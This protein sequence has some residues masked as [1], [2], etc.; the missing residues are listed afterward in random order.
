MVASCPTCDYECN[1]E[2][3]VKVHHTKVHGESLVLKEK[4]CEYCGEIDEVYPSQTED[5]FDNYFCSIRCRSDHFSEN[6]SGEDHP[7]WKGGQ[8]EVTCLRCD[9]IQQK[10]P[11]YARD[12]YGWDGEGAVE[13]SKCANCMADPEYNTRIP[14]GVNWQTQRRK[15][16]DRDGNAC[17]VCDMNNEVHKQEYSGFSL[18]VHHI[19]PRRDFYDGETGEFDYE[20]ANDLE[21]LIT[22]CIPHHDEA[23]R[24]GQT[25]F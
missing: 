24:T 8:I 12:K 25:Q 20:A 21:N 15:A 17:V 4:A 7:Q 10:D 14:T 19:I 18:H 16:R 11:S 13:I 3:G 6:N 2:M 5:C 9:F 1:T 22:L 23:E